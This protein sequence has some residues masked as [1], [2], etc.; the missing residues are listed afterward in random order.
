MPALPESFR[1]KLF[2]AIDEIKDEI[3]SETAKLLTFETISGGDT[4]E[5]REK[6]NIEFAKCHEHLKNLAE[7]YG[8]Q[9]RRL[10]DI[11]S[12][13][14]Q[15]ADEGDEK[16]LGI[17]L[18]ID[19]MPCTGE[20]KFP[21]FSGT[22]DNGIIWGRGTQDD[23]GPLTA[24]MYAII[25]LKKLNVKFTRPI[26]IVL[27]QAEEVGDWTDVQ[28][29][30]KKEGAPAFSFTP[31]AEFPIIN[32]EK[33]IMNLKVNGEWETSSACCNPVR[34]LNLKGGIRANAVPDVSELIF[35]ADNDEAVESLKKDIE[36]FLA[37]N[38]K[39][40]INGP[41]KCDAGIKITF[42]GESAHGSI[43]DHGHNAILDSLLFLSNHASVSKECQV[44]CTLLEDKCSK[45]FGKG[46]D[47]DIEHHFVGKTTVNL[48]VLNIDNKGG[49]AII[50]T[51]PTLGLK[52]AVAGKKASDIVKAESEKSGVKMY[53]EEGK[54][55][56]KEALFVD[57]EENKF[58]I[59]SLQEAYHDVT[60]LE[61][62]LQSI[63]GTTF[64]KAYPNCVSFGPIVPSV[65]D[66]LA[67]MTNEFVEVDCQIRNT[68]IYAYAFALLTT[69]AVKG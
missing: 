53:V 14:D 23:K 18:H 66:E 28:Y 30:L 4:E 34:F 13:I 10:D 51:R 1:D 7:K 49:K 32:G 31:D 9:Y 48:G 54:T 61:P 52:C 46:F 16:G 67:H 37:A 29:F 63:G 39:A 60:G 33:G 19:V 17:P 58:F 24:C 57:P 35:E 8:M 40:K 27:G 12:V 21:P 43:P 36:A 5:K 56:G 20:W 65:E 55:W 15:L 44:Y 42:L 26:H 59:S 25:A 38:P 50:N 68:K 47:I 41:E 6:C 64:A 11:V 2:Q 45:F 3:V 22:V 69:D 62:K